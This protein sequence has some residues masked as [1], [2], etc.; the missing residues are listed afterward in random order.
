MS[1]DDFGGYQI[2]L[3]YMTYG[4]ALAH[5]HRLPPPQASSA[6]PSSGSSTS[7]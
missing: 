2:Q 1:Q 6:Q 4:L 7:C 5:R 3:A